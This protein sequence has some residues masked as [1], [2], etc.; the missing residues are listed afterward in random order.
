MRVVRGLYFG[1]RA[2]AIDFP[3]FV[4]GIVFDEEAFLVLY[5]YEVFALALQ[6]MRGGIEHSFFISLAADLLQAC[7]LWRFFQGVS[8]FGVGKVGCS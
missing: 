2:E 6:C 8:R 7:F 5:Q 4:C 3:A 1:Q